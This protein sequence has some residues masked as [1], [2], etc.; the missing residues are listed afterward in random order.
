MTAHWVWRS[1]FEV[2]AVAEL[3]GAPAERRDAG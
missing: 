3:S 2:G 1:L